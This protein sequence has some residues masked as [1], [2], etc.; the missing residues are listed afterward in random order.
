MIATGTIGNII[1]ERYSEGELVDV[2]L[3]FDSGLTRWFP[4]AM[5]EDAGRAHTA[6]R[7]DPKD[8]L[9]YPCCGAADFGGHLAHVD[10]GSC[11]QSKLALALAVGDDQC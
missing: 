8:A 6:S 1:G 3:E 11:S 10:A 2:K 7:L 9:L 5:L 4:P